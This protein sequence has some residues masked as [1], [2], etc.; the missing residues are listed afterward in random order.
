M[1]DERE[2]LQAQLEHFRKCLTIPN[3]H[4]GKGQAKGRPSPVTPCPAADR[5]TDRRPMT[6][7]VR[8][9]TELVPSQRGQR[10]KRALDW[11]GRQDDRKGG[12]RKGGQAL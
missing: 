2:R 6:D 7:G 12:G 11:E 10:G 1:R 5:Q 8:E 3:V 9:D 4:W